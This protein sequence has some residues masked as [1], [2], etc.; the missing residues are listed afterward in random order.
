MLDA[1]GGPELPR[2]TIIWQLDRGVWLELRQGGT[3]VGEE[4]ADRTAGKVES[5]L[6]EARQKS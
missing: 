3:G 1:L 2:T 4:F 5:G 6:H